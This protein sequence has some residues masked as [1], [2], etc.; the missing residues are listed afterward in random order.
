MTRDLRE[1]MDALVALLEDI[2]GDRGLLA[3]LSAEER[4]RLIQAAGRSTTPTPAARR[5][6][7]K[8]I[9]KRRKADRAQARRSE[10]ARD[11]HPHAAAPAGVHDAERVRAARHS[12]PRDVPPA[13]DDEARAR[14]AA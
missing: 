7:V 13:D 6:L 12:S 1:Q 4:T 14:A 3:E 2:A 8:A 5:Q 9:E 10:A 11:R